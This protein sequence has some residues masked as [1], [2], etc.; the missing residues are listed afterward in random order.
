[1]ERATAGDGGDGGAAGRMDL[2][3]AALRAAGHAFERLAEAVE[4]PKKA[5]VPPDQGRDA[6][7]LAA[8]REENR[9]LREALESRSSIERAKGVLMAKHNCS[10]QEAFGILSAAA[11]RQQRKVRVVADELL[12]RLAAA[13]QATPVTAATPAT[14]VAPVTPAVPAAASAQTVPSANGTP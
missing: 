14:P 10:E 3:A 11:R 4:P 7:E 8:L 2:A 9:Q 13:T 5:P 6:A 12:G 1:M